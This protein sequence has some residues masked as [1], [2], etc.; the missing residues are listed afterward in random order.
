MRGQ[1]SAVSGPVPM[2][3]SDKST[4]VHTTKHLKKYDQGENDV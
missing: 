4:R 1:V 3:R 2:G